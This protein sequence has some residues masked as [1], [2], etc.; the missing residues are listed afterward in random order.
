M[1]KFDLAYFSED[2]FQERLQFTIDRLSKKKKPFQKPVAYLLGGQAGAGKT[3]LHAIIKDKL[4]NDVI[5]IDNDTF[6]QMHPNFDLL[7]DKYGKDYVA[8]VTPF[9]NKM[10]EALIE[11]FSSQGFNLTIEGTLRTIE[12]PM[13]TATSLKEKGYEVNLYAMAVSKDL[14]YLGTIERYESMYLID[15]QTARST[16]KAIH[17]TIVSNLPDNLDMLFNSGYFAE[18]SLF[19]REGTKVY[20]SVDTPSISPKQIIYEA[21]N[22]EIPKDVLINKIDHIIQLTKHNNHQV[23]DLLHWRKELIRQPI[24]PF[25]DDEKKKDKVFNKVNKNKVFER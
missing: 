11:H 17:D 7:V 4:N 22:Q 1:N 5:T 18:I 21:L 9:S 25:Q 8:H 23:P 3:T 10:T 24:S 19:T 13:Q 12:T 14:S 15:P 16:D 20:S 2:E 6:K